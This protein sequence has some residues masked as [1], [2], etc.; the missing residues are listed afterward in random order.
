MPFLSTRLERDS[1]RSRNIFT[2][3]SRPGRSFGTRRSVSIKPRSSQ[4]WPRDQAPG[5]TRPYWA[6]QSRRSSPAAALA[7]RAQYSCLKSA[8]SGFRPDGS[9]GWRCP[10]VTSPS[11][12]RGTSR[13]MRPEM[14]PGLAC[15]RLRRRRRRRG[16][17]TVV[18]PGY[19]CLLPSSPRIAH[20]KNRIQPPPS[21]VGDVPLTERF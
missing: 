14:P 20:G 11:R 13:T 16:K 18:L 10:C 12:S 1:D 21:G 19:R 5:E 6:H 17:K 4:P 3:R 2:G 9:L 15:C 7:T 8:K